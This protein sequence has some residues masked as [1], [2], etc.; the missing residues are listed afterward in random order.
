[1]IAHGGDVW[2]VADELGIS[3]SELL[4]FSA[5][6][7][8]RGLPP[9]ARARLTRDAS[10]SRL[11]SF[12]P[13]PTAR[14]LRQ[15]LSEQHAVA[16]GAI[17]VGT[18]ADSLLAPILRSL[19]PRRALVPVPAFSEYRRACEQE[20]IQFTPFPLDRA[21][22]FRINVDCLCRS[23]EAGSYGVVMLNQPHNPS[24]AVLERGEVQH[25]IETAAGSSA[26]VLLDEAFIDYVPDLSFIRKA[27]SRPGLIV[28]R[29]LT[30]FYGCPAL[31]VGYAVAHSETVSR[32]QS[33]MPAWPVTQLAIDALAEAVV[34]R[35]YA[36]TSIR[37]NA[38]ERERLAESLNGLGMVVFP[39]AANYLLVELG[40]DMPA[41]AELRARLIATHRILIRNCD[42]YEGLAPG[43]YIRVA[44]RTAADNR[45]LIEALAVE[46]GLA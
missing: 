38:V 12:Y 31:R 10:D 40:P 27:A 18:G 20:H 39:A 8:P 26:T 17:V 9:G 33:L 21:D 43:R 6:I 22:L 2:Q 1:M 30:K 23:I 29:S 36:E 35:E 34:D 28:V 7:N 15:A 25:V 13:D 14:R 5:S 44:V 41:A 11:L 32:I 24:G 46:C 19:D 4:D 37:E 16:P 3:A 45:R 42:S